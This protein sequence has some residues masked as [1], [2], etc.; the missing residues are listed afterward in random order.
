MAQRDVFLERQAVLACRLSSEYSQLQTARRSLKPPWPA[1][2]V[3]QGGGSKC[4]KHRQ[5]ALLMWP[6]A[7]PVRGCIYSSCSAQTSLQLSSSCRS[8]AALP[9]KEVQTAQLCSIPCHAME[10]PVPGAW[11]QFASPRLHLEPP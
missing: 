10:A 11:Q 2:S 3:A 9:C 8:C 4:T 6:L 1:A 5:A 7:Q